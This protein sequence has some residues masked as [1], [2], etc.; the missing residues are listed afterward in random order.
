[1]KK[2]VVLGAGYAGVLIAKKLAKMAKKAKRQ[3]EITLIDRNPF[4][5]MLTE[6]HEV[7]A[8]RVD[9]SSIRI[10]LKKIFSGRDVNVVMDDI[11][12]VDYDQRTL[13]GKAGSYKYDRLVL[14]T[15][16]KPT[17]WGVPGA[18]EHAFPLW[19]YADSLRLRE[20]VMS[21]F[22][23]ASTETDPERKKA[24][25][26]FYI[27][28]AGFT[29]VEM[30]GELAEFV[31]FACEKFGIN[32]AAVKI[33]LL[34]ALSRIMPIFPEKVTD[35]AMRRFEEMGVDVMLEAKITGLSEGGIEYELGGKKVVDASATVIWSAGT[36][37]SEIALAAEE[38]GIEP[39]SRGRVRADKYLRSE[40]DKNVYVAGDNMFYIPEG[41]SA[42]VPQMV[43]NCEHCAK[44]IAINIMA[45]ASGAQPQ[46]EYKPSFHGAMVSIGGKYGVAYVGTAANS[47]SLASFFAMLAKHVVNMIY[48]VQ[49]LG[50]NKV[51]A[52]IYTEFFTMRNRRSFVGGHFS[53]RTPSFLLVPLRLFMGMFFVY[54]AYRRFTLGW[55]DANMLGPY[56]ES[57]RGVFRPSL[58][59][60]EL[61]NQFRFSLFILN[62]YV[63]MWFQMMPFSWFVE[64]FVIA[65]EA[66]IMFWQWAIVL[67]T[68]LVGLALIA[69][70]FTT[71]ASFYVIFYA[72]V[73]ILSGGLAFGNMWIPFAGLAM[74]F[75]GGK[76]L[77]F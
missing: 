6:L 62:D 25:L 67:S 65:S 45:E 38:L 74:M 44:V 76:V 64:T 57:L 42:P 50:W 30:A 35:K 3:V 71:L 53:N 27:I 2:V 46:L 19:S 56:F 29:G 4:H 48:F 26:N 39:K 51:G 47:I 21:M 22:R 55:L 32:P 23:E 31:P 17:Y 28:G 73:Y 70:W 1:M 14:A 34:D 13:R 60:I 61:W 37:G 63:H 18:K 59:E 52:Y 58:L 68:L 11:E 9:E 43:E 77:A 75:S 36:E 7:A 41:E 54:Y 49:V 8:W 66:H 24:M 40:K 16:C 12:S 33:H 20:H 10:D 5:T 72:V 69:G 15:G